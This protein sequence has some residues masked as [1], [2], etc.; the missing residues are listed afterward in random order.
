MAADDVLLFGPDLLAAPVTRPGQRRRRL[1]VPRGHWVDVWR[2][3]RYERGTGGLALGAGAARR[4][5]RDAAGAA[6]R[7]AAARARG[8]S[9]RSCRP[10]WTLSSAGPGLVN[11]A[12]RR[13][14]S[15]CSRSHAGR[16]APGS[17]RTA[18]SAPGRDAGPG[19][20]A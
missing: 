12:D 4:A 2:S 11:L 16:R 10:T 6:R 20:S 7:A 5:R 17:A 18:G 15:V 9:S 13:P 3:V 14:A 19:R 8:R 1:Y